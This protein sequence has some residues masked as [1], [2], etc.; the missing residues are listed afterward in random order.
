MLYLLNITN[1]ILFHSPVEQNPLKTRISTC[2]IFFLI[3]IGRHDVEQTWQEE[4]TLMRLDPCC[5][6]NTFWQLVSPEL[7]MAPNKVVMSLELFNKIPGDH[8]KL[9]RMLLLFRTL[10][11]YLRRIPLR[12]LLGRDQNLTSHGG[13][14]TYTSRSRVRDVWTKAWSKPQTLNLRKS[15][16]IISIWLSEPL[17]EWYPRCRASQQSA[18]MSYQIL[19]HSWNY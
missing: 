6:V 13:Y 9:R 2:I 16:R 11:Y 19:W 15:I 7:I 17:W 3:C 8:D 12:G 18:I 14:V 4:D 1:K 5:S 10:S